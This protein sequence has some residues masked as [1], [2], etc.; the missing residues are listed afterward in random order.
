MQDGRIHMRQVPMRNGAHQRSLDSA[1]SLSSQD[2]MRN[3]AKL[4]ALEL[5]EGGAAGGHA[6]KGCKGAAANGTAAQPPAQ[7]GAAK[8][9]RPA[10]GAAAVA[11]PTGGRDI[12]FCEC[13][14]ICMHG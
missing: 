5:I 12:L 2:S 3:I 10:L 11:Q 6:Q 14:V 8:E 9:G 1:D 4:A 7:N 13:T